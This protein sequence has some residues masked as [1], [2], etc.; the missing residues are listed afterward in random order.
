MRILENRSNW[1]MILLF[2]GVACL[3]GCSSD[4]AKVVVSGTV[5]FDGEPVEKGQIAFEP[6]GDGRMEF[7]VITNGH[8]SI[9]QEFG[10]VP[11]ESI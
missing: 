2:L 4:T 6:Q 10:L 1:T 7:G 5:S 9:P 8:Y 3:Q 11:G